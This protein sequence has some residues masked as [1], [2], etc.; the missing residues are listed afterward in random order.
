MSSMEIDDKEKT[1]KTGK[2]VYQKAA[3]LTERTNF[4]F[5]E[6]ESAATGR[7]RDQHIP[8]LPE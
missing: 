6:P 8:H 3:I 2:K 1:L 5:K 7:G 4:P